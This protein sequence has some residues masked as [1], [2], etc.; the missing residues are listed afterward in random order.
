MGGQQHQWDR[1]RLLG[2]MYSLFGSMRARHVEA[3]L[4]SHSAALIENELYT[5]LQCV[6]FF[7]AIEVI[8]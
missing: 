6:L 2:E 3:R 7:Y 8:V 5:P 1:L 4:P